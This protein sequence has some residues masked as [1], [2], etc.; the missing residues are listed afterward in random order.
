MQCTVTSKVSNDAIRQIKT[1]TGIQLSATSLASPIAVRYAGF[2]FTRFTVRP[3]GK[4]PL[5]YLLCTP[6]VSPLCVFGEP[7]FAMIP[8]HEV[9]AAKFTN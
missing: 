6:Y 5:Q 3:D 7:V 1:N 9:R 2:M 8:D 4:T